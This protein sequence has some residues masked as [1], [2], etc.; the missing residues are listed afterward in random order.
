VKVFLGVPA[1]AAIASSAGAL[2][3]QLQ[4]R[5]AV[6]A[7]HARISWVPS[8]RFHLTVLFIG[9][10]SDAQFQ[11]ICRALSEAFAEGPFALAIEG[12]GAFPPRGTPRVLWAGCGSGR[13]AFV[14]LQREAYA[15][16]SA[17][18]ALDAERD[19]TPHLTLARV[20]EPAG[21]QASALFAGLDSTPLG[22]ITVN[23]VT[24]FESRPVRNGVQY[25][26]MM[27]TALSSR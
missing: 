12:A 5:A 13:E 7:P 2:S 18:V 20:K 6:Q 3:R 9:H 26:P 16:V 19:A 14:R 17:L 11:Q 22:T 23:A 1:G 15:R 27:E 10:V 4:D 21:L 8:D 25:V 24:L